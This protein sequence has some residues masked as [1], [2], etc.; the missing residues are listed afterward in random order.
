MTHL[1]VKECF[2]FGGSLSD[3]QLITASIIQGSVVGPISYAINASDLSTG[4]R[5]HKYA[6]DT[7]RYIVIPPCNI[8]SREVELDHVAN[9]ALTN[10]LPII[11]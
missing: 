10:N 7:Y 5:M 8:Q 2:C 1:V 4:N 9:W 6:D 3:F 11:S